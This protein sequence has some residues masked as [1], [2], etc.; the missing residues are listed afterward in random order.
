MKRFKVDFKKLLLAEQVFKDILNK[1]GSSHL[2]ACVRCG[3]CG[4]SCHIYLAEPVVQNLPVS[5]AQQV[6]AL[7]RRYHT[8][9]GKLFPLLVGAKEFSEESLNELAESVFE[10]C[11]GCGRCSINCSIGVDVASIVRMGRNILASIEE[12]P[13]ELHDTT[14]NQLQTGNQMSITEQEL[15]DTALWIADDLRMETG[16]EEIK[17]PVDQVGA[18][19]LYLVNPR[20]VKFFPLSLSAAAAIFASAKESWTIASR[21]FDVTNYGFFSGDNKSA[22]IITNNIFEEAKKLQVQEIVL[23]ECGH[24]FRAFRWEGAN[25]LERKYPIPVRSVLE[26]ILEYIKDERITLDK[27]KNNIKVTLHDP[28]NLVRW[29]GVISPQ[30]E[31]LAA[32]VMDFVEMIPNREQN[33][34]CGGGGGMLA[35][36]EC[37]ERR[38]KSGKIK[39]DQIRNTKAKIV[40]TPCHNCAD[41]LLELNKKYALGIEIQS[42]S[43]LVFNALKWITK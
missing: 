31:I 43:E 3:L 28:C 8:L 11:T 5:K 40:A 39:A 2:N 12:I 37:G 38:I 1:N 26:L 15:N 34:C 24:G 10:R 13:S 18:K 36:S 35:I 29:G 23:S 27:S 21:F 20:E 25:W 33:F 6:S 22:A 42:I 4:Q 30:R 14:Q 19:I 9:S 32:A 16:V 41:Q 17:I 7:F